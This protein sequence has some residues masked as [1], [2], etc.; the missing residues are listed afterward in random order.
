MKIKKSKIALLLGSLLLLSMPLSSAYAHEDHCEIEDTQLGNMMKS[1]KSELRGYVKSFKADD[2]QKM[3]QHINELLTLNVM[4]AKQTPV[5]IK[6]MDSDG[7]MDHSKISMDDMDHSEMGMGNM[8][9]MDHSKMNQGA[10][11]MDSGSHDMSAM[12]SMKGMSA[13]QHHQHMQYMQAMT[14]LN[15]LFKQ[16]AAT[17]NKTDIKTILNK[18]K[19]HIRK[20][21]R[22]FRQDCD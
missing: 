4:A 9:D 2:P 13:E 21:H 14:G 17:Q 6:H 10:M 12:P 5:K 22:Q 16:L 18:I 7:E 1:M 8:S 15:D 3:Q 19:E 20:S 11:K